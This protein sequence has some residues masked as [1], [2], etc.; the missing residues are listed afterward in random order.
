MARRSA[1][2]TRRSLDHV[3]GVSMTD[4]A[5]DEDLFVGALRGLVEGLAR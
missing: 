2:A 1:D 5:E 3:L 4:P